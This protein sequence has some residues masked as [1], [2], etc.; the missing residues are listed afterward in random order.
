MAKM[1]SEL[2]A[3]QGDT[4]IVEVNNNQRTKI[5][6]N[7]KAIDLELVP[8]APPKAI[9]GGPNTPIVTIGNDGEMF[10]LDVPSEAQWSS[11][12]PWNDCFCD[13]QIRTRSCNYDSSAH[14]K[15]CQGKSFESR[16]CITSRPCPAKIALKRNQARTTPN[17]LN[18]NGLYTLAP[19][20]GPRTGYAFK[21]NPLSLAISSSSSSSSQTFN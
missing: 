1:E 13:K 2:V 8:K 4:S 18:S 17:P 11:W 7:L 5:G 19:Q 15:G 9:I 6:P 14:S 20:K 12:K 21:P 10:L 16:P 3:L